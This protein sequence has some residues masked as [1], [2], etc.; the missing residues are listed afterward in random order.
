[1]ERLTSEAKRSYASLIRHIRTLR[2]RNVQHDVD[3]L[4]H[5]RATSKLSLKSI[6]YNV[7]GHLIARYLQLNKM[8]SKCN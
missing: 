1:M 3:L 8:Y 5:G 2:Q 4:V 7:F 6:D